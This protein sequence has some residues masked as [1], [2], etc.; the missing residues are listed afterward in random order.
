MA[1]KGEGVGQITTAEQLLS[2]KELEAISN[3]LFWYAI[4]TLRFLPAMADKIADKFFFPDGAGKTIEYEHKDGKYSF[5][6]NYGFKKEDGLKEFSLTILRT[7]RDAHKYG[8]IKTEKLIIEGASGFPWPSVERQLI[9][10]KFPQGTIYYHATKHPDI[11]ETF[12]NSDEV[13]DKVAVFL[14]TLAGRHVENVHHAIN[15]HNEP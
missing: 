1:I 8:D 11:T 9:L 6:L 15:R 10:D 7:P 14:A 13:L 4:R 3:R 12:I 2:P 5:L